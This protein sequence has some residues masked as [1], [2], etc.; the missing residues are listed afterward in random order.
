MTRVI[1]VAN[2]KGGVGKTTTVANLGVALASYGKRVMLVDLDSQAALTATFGLNP[3]KL[4]RTT[5][6]ILIHERMAL[7]R[8]LHPIGD[9]KMAIAPASID[10]AA[11]EVQLANAEGRARRLRDA[12]ERNRIPFDYI[13][14]D[15]PPSLGLLTLNGLVAGTD[16][17]IPVQCHYLAMRGVRS[18]MEVVW[19][20]KRRL[21]PDLK[22]LGLIP[23]M[24]MPGSEHA[25]EVLKELRDVFRNKVFDIV[26]E[27]SPAFAEAPAAHQTVVEYAPDHK[28]A[29]AYRKLAEVIINYE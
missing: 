17:L 29:I 25:E 3:Y 23:T 7:A 1:V 20:V 4:E 18:L 6:S 19:R 12:L 13:V 26:I 15:T 27:N 28:G 11:A 22:L 2:Q 16:V 10:L 5:Y 9:G 24:Y 21:N 8:T 14:V